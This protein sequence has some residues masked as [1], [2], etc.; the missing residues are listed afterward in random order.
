MSG[1]PSLINS[2]LNHDITRVSKNPGCTKQINMFKVSDKF[3]VV[4]V[5]GYGYAK[6]SKSLINQ[7]RMMIYKYIK[8]RANLRKG[9]MLLDIRRKITAEDIEVIK[10]FAV[11]GVPLQIILTKI[12]KVPD[13]EKERTTRLLSNNIDAL[14]EKYIAL[15]SRIIATSSHLKIGLSPVG[16]EIANFI[17]LAPGSDLS[18]QSAPTLVNAS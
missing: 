18:P 11:V 15:D 2:L 13:E 5:P 12:D 17:S 1:S 6:A 9:F 3:M 4:D 8:F 16:L 14:G 10:L 7:W